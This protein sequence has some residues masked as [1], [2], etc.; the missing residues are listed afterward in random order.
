MFAVS[1]TDA[2][3]SCSNPTVTRQDMLRWNGTT[4]TLFHDDYYGDYMMDIWMISASNGWIVG[5][6][7]KLFRWTGG[8]SWN[9]LPSGTTAHLHGIDMVS[10]IDGWIVGAAGTILRWNGSA[11]TAVSPAP[12]TADLNDIDLVSATDGFA[13]G[14]GGAILRYR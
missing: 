3:T 9:D 6:N 13:V 11:W 4:W 7:G 8:P 14:S 10:S 12:T 2:W 1:E 5:H